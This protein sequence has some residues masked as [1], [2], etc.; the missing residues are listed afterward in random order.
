MN[1]LAL[2]QLALSAL[3]IIREA[4]HGNIED[5]IITEVKSGLEQ[6][7]NYAKQQHEEQQKAQ[8]TTKPPAEVPNAA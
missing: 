3:H 2:S 5:K 8:E 4:K 1:F 6:L 7:S